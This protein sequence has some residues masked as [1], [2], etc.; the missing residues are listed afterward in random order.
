M[1]QPEKTGKGQ[2]ADFVVL[3][4][5]ELCGKKDIIVLLYYSIQTKRTL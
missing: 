3:N 1:R 5:G 4:V 2:V